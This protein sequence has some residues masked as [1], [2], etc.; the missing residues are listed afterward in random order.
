M[1]ALR[2]SL[3]VALLVAAAGALIAACGG[4][5]SG[6]ES[7][8][9]ATA[10]DRICAE[11]ARRDVAARSARPQSQAAYLRELR[12]NRKEALS[13]LDRLTPP[14]AA[15]ER[16]EEFFAIRRE[17]AIRIE[18]GIEAAEEGDVFALRDF[19]L[20]AR[21]RVVAA[22]AIA[23]ALGLEACAGLLPAR[24][25]A[26]VASAIDA[27]IDP[28]RSHRFCRRHTTATMLAST[29]GSLAA[30]VQQQARRTA[31]EALRIEELFGVA[32]VSA[33]AIV[34][35]T[36]DGEAVGRYEIALVH[37]GDTWR[38]DGASPAPES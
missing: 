34:T 22:Q 20:A 2:D 16:F 18:E 26:A 1:I 37:E 30:C 23:A 28:D 12:R 29:F 36:E 38:Y 11:T 21:E 32:G 6:G 31:P 24:E 19:R 9:F 35:L 7:E 8:D 4:G 3:T 17:A 10:A 25:R 15:A 14:P 33:S 13:E 5:E 27:S